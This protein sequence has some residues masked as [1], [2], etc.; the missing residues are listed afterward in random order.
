[1]MLGGSLI[2]M[3]RLRIE[4]AREAHDVVMGDQRLAGLEAHA[5]LEVVEPLDHA[6][7]SF[8]GCG[9]A[10]SEAERCAADP[11]SIILRDSWTPGLHRNTSCCGAPGEQR[12][13]TR[14]RG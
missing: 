3:E 1:G 6:R 4:L 10:R 12:E 11:G 7:A 9:A 14:L 5:E 13:I 2:E 8:P